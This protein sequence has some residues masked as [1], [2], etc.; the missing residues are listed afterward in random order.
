AMTLFRGLADDLP[1]MTWLQDH[2]FPAEAGL[3][4]DQVYWGAL[5]ACAEM[6]RSG[7]TCF[8]DMYLFTQAVA[9]AVEAAGLRAVVGEVLFDFPSP[10]YG[11][12]EQGFAY[13]E[14]L[15][16]TWRDN[17]LISI[18]VEP[19]SP[20]L[21]APEL[22]TRAAALAE[23][24]G[25][26]LVIH[27]SET[28]SEVAQIE[29]KTG[30]TPVGHLADLGVLGPN[31]IAPHCVVLTDTDRQLLARHGVK[32]AHNPHS[33]M[34][35]ASGVAPVPELLAAGVCVGLGTDGC[36]SNNNLD[37]FAEM[38]VTAKLHKVQ[39]L[40][41]TVMDAATTLKLAT[42]NGASALGLN[43]A[44]G[45][46]SVGK[47][48]DIIIID[49]AQPHLTPMY[50]PVSHLVYAAGGHDVTT[51]IVNGRVLMADRRLTTLDEIEV[52]ARVN[53]FARR[54]R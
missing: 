16:R 46:L 38:D 51:T 27:L 31:L 28:Q 45:S 53:E 32:V 30:H 26:C 19:H 43:E 54:I 35:L 49:S 5:L 4:A 50:N 39:S 34:K 10:N 23:E 40:D 6:I 18:A 14:D 3:D 11:P 48:A 13:T 37:M 21:C 20:Y 17:P 1:L 52:M 33:N 29:A 15:V 9:K 25:L 8:C 24:Q 2:I 44:I 36:A 7:T 47:R 12:I 41:P 42:G 22:L